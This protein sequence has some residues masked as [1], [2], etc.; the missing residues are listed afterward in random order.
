M[1]V[2]SVSATK[3]PQAGRAINISLEQILGKPPS[4]KKPLAVHHLDE[5][6]PMNPV[7][8]SLSIAVDAGMDAIL[9]AL[10]GRVANKINLQAYPQ[11]LCEDGASFVTLEKDGKL[12]GCIGSTQAHRPLIADVIGNAIA[13][14]FYDSRFPVL[15][16]EEI[17]M[18]SL[19]I[20]VLGPLTAFVPPKEGWSDGALLQSLRRDIDG[21]VIEAEGKRSIYLPQVWQM[22]PSAEIFLGQLKHK[23]KLNPNCE[24]ASMKAW[25][26]QVDKTLPKPFPHIKV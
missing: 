7:I 17:N 22:M 19:S 18:M 8:G 16:V 11:V 5:D 25:T 15:A 10:Q 21:L 2:D 14:G 6:T 23:A 20:S 9:E 13:A 4:A 3:K 12:R 26:Y 24:Y 1:S